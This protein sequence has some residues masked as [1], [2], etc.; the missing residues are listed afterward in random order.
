MT[1]RFLLPETFK[2]P[3]SRVA[4]IQAAPNALFLCRC[5]YHVM[6]NMFQSWPMMRVLMVTV[7]AQAV[8]L[9][10]GDV[11]AA[12]QLLLAAGT[13]LSAEL[14]AWQ[15]HISEAAESAVAAAESTVGMEGL[16]EAAV[17]SAQA[18]VAAVEGFTPQVRSCQNFCNERGP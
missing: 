14:R 1:I 7:C 10:P 17:A 2:L 8:D 13:R 3:P 15:R 12:L 5:Q 9:S 18:I 6:G 4:L 16:H 11:A